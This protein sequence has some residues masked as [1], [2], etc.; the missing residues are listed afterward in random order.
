LDVALITHNHISLGGPGPRQGK[1]IKEEARM[2][3]V[4]TVRGSLR[5][6]CSPQV[7]ST[8]HLGNKK[9][10]PV[11]ADKKKNYGRRNKGECC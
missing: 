9:E 1:R 6:M 3:E 10:T 5:N 8:G 2:G 7:R 11:P 4:E